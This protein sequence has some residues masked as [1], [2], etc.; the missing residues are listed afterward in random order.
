MASSKKKKEK[1][2]ELEAANHEQVDD[3]FFYGYN[4][5][6][7]KHKITNG[8]PN[9]L[10]DD[11]DETDLSEDTLVVDKQDAQGKDTKTQLSTST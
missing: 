7:R 9:I 2:K 4:C 11:N 10:Y 5:C 6:I 3:M 1:K 8:I